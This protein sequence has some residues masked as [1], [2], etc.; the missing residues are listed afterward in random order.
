[1]RQR[2][3]R[4]DCI[5]DRQTTPPPSNATEPCRNKATLPIETYLRTLETYLRTLTSWQTDL[6]QKGLTT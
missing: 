3:G 2:S 1:M 5:P 4:E 6:P